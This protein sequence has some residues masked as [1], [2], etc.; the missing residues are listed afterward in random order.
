[1]ITSDTIL[2]RSRTS[3]QLESTFLF[4]EDDHPPVPG[5]EVMY[6]SSTLG[7]AVAYLILGAQTGD[8]RC[9]APLF[10]LVILVI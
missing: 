7:Y 5:I 9:H 4:Q 2:A 1:M 3:M 10:I 8:Q 6:E